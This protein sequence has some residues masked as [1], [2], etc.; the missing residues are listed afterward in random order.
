MNQSFASLLV[1]SASVVAPLAALAAPITVPTDLNPGDSYRLAF[2]TNTTSDATSS[3]IEDYNAF[4][5]TLA[6][7]I[8]ELAALKTTWKAIVSTSTVDAR[9]NTSTNWVTIPVGV[10]I[11]TLG[12]TRVASTNTDLWSFSSTIPPS[13]V[14]ENAITYTESGDSVP[15]LTNVWSGTRYDGTR[16]SVQFLGGPG[17]VSLGNAGSLTSGW[18]ENGFVMSPDI[19]NRVYAMSGVLTVVPEPSTFALVALA[20][21]GFA[22][23]G[24]RRIRA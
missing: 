13:P 17:A 15:N 6:N 22:A 8:P 24:W 23:W 3:N 20:C 5:T 9:D 7:S 2:V 18:I 10:P 16:Q 1:I 12:G 14:H 21:V 4:A 11:Y 19:L